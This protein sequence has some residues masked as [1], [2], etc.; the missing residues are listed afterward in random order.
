MKPVPSGEKT[1]Q[2]RGE[3]RGEKGK[4]LG[5]SPSCHGRRGPELHFVLSSTPF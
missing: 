1:K 3:E 5:E 4:D 2:W